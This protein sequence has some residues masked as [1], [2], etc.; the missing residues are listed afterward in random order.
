MAVDQREALIAAVRAQVEKERAEKAAKLKKEQN[1]MKFSNKAKTEEEGKDSKP[2][3]KTLSAEDLAKIEEKKMRKK[4]EAMGISYEEMI[5]E[6]NLGPDIAEVA[7]EV[8]ETKEEKTVA[9]EKKEESAVGGLGAAPSGGGLGSV[10]TGGL[11]GGLGGSTAGGLGGSS[12]KKGGLGLNLDPVK[13][14]TSSEDKVKVIQGKNQSFSSDGTKTINGGNSKWVSGTDNKKTKGKD[15][16]K[17]DELDSILPQNRTTPTNDVKSMYDIDDEEDI[18]NSQIM[19]LPEVEDDGAAKRAEEEAKKKADE[20]AKKKAEA[21]AKKKAEAEAKKKAE[22]EA[23][24]KAEE[25]KREG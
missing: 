9:E 24:K 5:A 23:K 4:A 21:E 18:F 20:E 1:A 6:E 3:Y 22:V 14:D 19:D 11:G 12:D 8:E 10:P 2:K 16:K 17:A 15:A 25:A 7:R 13:V